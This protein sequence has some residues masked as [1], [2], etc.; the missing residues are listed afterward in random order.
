MRL[1]REPL[2]HFLLLGALVYGGAR[3]F[4]DAGERHIDAG[5]AQRARLASVYRLQYGTPPTESQLDSLLEQYVRG[6]VLYREGLALGLDRGDEIVRR[7]VIQKVEF[8]NQDAEADVPD[9][10]QLQAFFRGHADRYRHP[11][12]V[13]FEQRFFSP[14][15][16]GEADARQRAERALRK[17]ARSSGVAAANSQ[18]QGDAFADGAV[19]GSLDRDAITR[20]F[21]DSPLADAVFQ[22]PQGVWSGPYRSGL[23]WHLVRVIRHTP[24]REATFAEVSSRVAADL[25][26]DV[27]EQRNEAEYRRL[28]A[29]YRIVTE[30][31]PT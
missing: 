10:A 16:A 6:E 28:A 27:S 15:L 21:G 17:L 9:E 14:D 7:R 23:G 19:F 26:R 25:R 3:L 22:A 18:P 29:K 24:A 12:D 4:A 1:A 31:P 8:L 30:G 5:E 2:V 13:S 20:I 11:A